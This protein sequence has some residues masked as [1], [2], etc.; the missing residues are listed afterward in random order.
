M[1]LAHIRWSRSPSTTYTLVYIDWYSGR[2]RWSSFLFSF[3]GAANPRSRVAE[4]TPV[5]K[6]AA[7]L[8]S[9]GHDLTDTLTLPACTYYVASRPQ[10][11]RNK[12]QKARLQVCECDETLYYFFFANCNQSAKDFLIKLKLLLVNAPISI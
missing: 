4:T 7:E 10:P 5:R 8:L 3:Y 2:A 1:Y 11:R 6:S 9:R 12:S